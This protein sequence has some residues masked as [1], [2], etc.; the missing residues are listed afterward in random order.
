MLVVTT[1]LPTR[2][3]PEVGSFVLRDIEMLARDHEVH[4]LH[5]SAGGTT[6]PIDAET[7]S[8]TTLSMSPANPFSIARAARAISE[9]AAGADLVHSMAASALLPFRMFRSERPWV[10]TE[11][12]SALL[13]PSTVGPIAR[14]AIPLTARLLDRPDI[15]IAVGNGLASAIKQRRSGPTVVIPNAV[16]RSDDIRERP[17]GPTIR[18]VAVG[19]LIARKGPDVAIGT[20]AELRARGV[21]ATLDWV[22]EGPLRGEL[23][24]LAERLGVRDHVRL[25]GACPPRDIPAILA[26]A[27]VFLLPTTMETFGVAIA[28]ALVAG[29]PVVVGGAGE[30]ASFVTEPDGVLVHE[31]TPAAYADGVQRVL[32]M[33]AGRPAAEIA[34]R[35]AS[36]FDPEAR[37]AAYSD[38]YHRA[39]AL[40]AGHR[41]ER[42]VDVI[43]AVHDARRRVDRA[44]HSAL[45][46]TSVSRVIVVC[47]DVDPQR[48]DESLAVDDPRV[49]LVGFHDGIRS[50]AGPFNHGLDIAT[51]RFVA[52]LGSDDELTPGALDAWRRT[53]ERDA[54][55]VVLAPLRHASGARVPTPPTWRRRRLHG[56]RDRLAYRTAPLGIVARERLGGLRLTE[57]LATG[58]DLAFTARLWF[59]D[60]RLSRHAGADDYV[61]HD[62]EGR[63]TFTTRP[64]NEE[65]RAVELLI[66]DAWVRVLSEADR[67]AIATKLWRVNVFG[68]V[69]YRAGAWTDSDRAWLAGLV[70]ELHDFAPSATGRLS[71]A[72]AA[73][74]AALRDRSLP[75]AE[76]DR[77]SRRRRRFASTAALIPDRAALLLAR[78]A[79]LRFS[80]ATWWAGRR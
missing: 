70:T 66:R 43:V 30:Q 3:R 72:D 8:L 10:H 14:A 60:F 38:V 76:V 37:R 9:Y 55:D 39:A 44:V 41:S 16:D 50:P 27:D 24:S 45:T 63:V 23:V 47:H 36:T 61:I 17:L 12:W 20:I 31:Q 5:L 65:L 52:I 73:L 46:S 71:R 62:G 40:S 79:P 2:E 13:A 7:A 75:D 51:G 78:D 34:A 1:W 48:I 11:H 25:R 67:T 22:G 58:E 56:G 69:H 4:V 35:A 19:G 49:E 28:E 6:L 54:A 29:R 68:A 18:L 26:E 15:V 21:N 64:L 53:A 57:R 74:V 77:R 80:A 42:D 59:G 33:N 32:A